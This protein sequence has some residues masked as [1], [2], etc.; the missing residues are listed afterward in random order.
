[1]V[2]ICYSNGKLVS[3]PASEDIPEKWCFIWWLVMSLP[4]RS[5]IVEACSKHFSVLE[6]SWFCLSPKLF[7]LG[8]S[9]IKTWGS[10]K[11]SL[12]W[13]VF[14]CYDNS[15]H[16]PSL[17]EDRT[18]SVKEAQSLGWGIDMELCCLLPCSLWLPQ[19]S[20][21]YNSGQSAKGWHC[22]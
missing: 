21:I 20:F 15:F 10:K 1:M 2:S 5:T 4:F 12:S 16:S 17:Q 19:L 14:Y 18:G 9:N 3:T 8:D 22:Q 13:F 7:L 6:N 11:I